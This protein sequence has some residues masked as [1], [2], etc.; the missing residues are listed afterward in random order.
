MA[1]R[2]G[3]L[4][5]EESESHPQFLELEKEL[6]VCCLLMLEEMAWCRL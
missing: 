6:G 3:W 5:Y 1:G 2:D 4:G